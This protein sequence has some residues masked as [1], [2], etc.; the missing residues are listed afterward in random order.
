[1]RL[2]GIVLALMMALAPALLAPAPASAQSAVILPQGQTQFL[3]ANGKPLAGGNVGFYVP[4]NTLTP[5]LTWQ[6]AARVTPNANPVL[7][8]GSGRATIYG[9]GAYRQ[10]VKDAL[11]NTIWDSQ[12]SGLGGSTYG[13]TSTG[14]ANAQVLAT[15]DFA[16]TDGQTVT[17]IAGFTN[18]GSMTL[19]AGFGP[20]PLYV[21]SASGPIPMSGGEVVAGNTTVASW[22]V[23]NSRFT[24]ISAP[25]L[26]TPVTGI[27]VWANMAITS[28]VNAGALTISLTSANGAAISQSNPLYL[29]FYTSTLK[30]GKNSLI[31]LTSPLSLTIGSGNTLGVLNST[32]FGLI[33]GI[34]NNSGVYHLVVYNAYSNTT[35]GSITRSDIAPLTTVGVGATTVIGGAANSALTVYSDFTSAAVP[36]TVVGYLRWSS[37][38]PT[39]GSWTSAADVSQTFPASMTT[40]M[41]IVEKTFAVLTSTTSGAGTIPEGDAI[42]TIS[43]GFILIGTPFTP[44]G[45][46]DVICVTT[47][48]TVS[49]SLVGTNSGTVLAMFWNSATNASQVALVGPATAGGIYTGLISGCILAGTTS[50]IVVEVHGGNSNASNVVTLNGKGG[51]RV[52]GGTPLSRL[53]LEEYSTGSNA[54]N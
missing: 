8:D 46:T 24:L 26:P 51:S 22:S 6:D 52:F 20:Q 27:Q 37:G 48:L 2:R 18:T 38:L 15:S 16:N 17:F 29:P 31:K 4:P 42:P 43:Q 34:A 5:K 32:P 53:Y 45:P 33:V 21:P 10:I 50:P 41:R 40:P 49:N 28:S 1:M 39:A 3:D 25:A 11:N 14:S 12:T 54:W 23:A 9:V 13:G 7:L 35:L 19:D 44:Q 36:T 30:D 47:E